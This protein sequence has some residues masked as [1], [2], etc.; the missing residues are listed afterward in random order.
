MF[1]SSVQLL[2]QPPQLSGSL[3]GL[4]HTPPQST[5]PGGHVHSPETQLAPTGQTFVQLP[6]RSRLLDTSTH[7]PSQ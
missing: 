1:G 7:A 6:Q 4:T 3:E 5:W 2:P